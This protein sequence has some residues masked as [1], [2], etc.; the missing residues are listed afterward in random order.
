[1]GSLAMTSKGKYRAPFE[2]FMP[3]V[4]FIELGNLEATKITIELGNTNAIFVEPIEGEEGIY[5]ATNEFMKGLCNLCDDGGVFLVFD[6]VQ[7][8]MS[9]TRKLWSHQAY[10][11][12]RDIMTLAKL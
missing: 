10:D 5:S 7:C 3:R 1:M 12:E 11:V 9:Q 6:E 2:H 4:T 8:G